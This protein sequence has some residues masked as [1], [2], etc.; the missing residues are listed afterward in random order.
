MA[1]QKRPSLADQLEVLG[2]KIKKLEAECPVILN[3]EKY[4][5]LRVDGHCFHT[6]T[7]KFD[8]PCSS[9]IVE[10]MI[11]SAEDWMKTFQGVLV[12]VQSDEATL[13]LPPAKPETDLPFRGRSK[14]IETLSAGFFSARF[15]YHLAHKTNT[16]AYF[17]C[18]AFQ[19][20]EE[21][22]QDVFK[23]R[24]LDAYRNGVSSIA[25]SVFS[26]KQLHKCGTGV[27]IRMLKEKNV[28][29]SKLPAHLLHGTWIKKCLVEKECAYHKTE[30]LVKVIRCTTVRKTGFMEYALAPLPS[31]EWMVSQYDPNI[32]H[33]IP[34]I[35]NIMTD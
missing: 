24:M 28:D 22:I 5:C 6:F 29:I 10:A 13:L 19:P 30:E 14:K 2:T 11:L 4:T 7:R 16:T 27:Q 25:R 33:I 15:N 20:T 32:S 17:D 31:L 9:Y 21:D 23:W 12:Y 18:R 3:K 35:E 8:K 34:K 26:T 1:E